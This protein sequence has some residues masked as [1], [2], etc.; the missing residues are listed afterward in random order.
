MDATSTFPHIFQ[1]LQ[2]R[3]LKLQNRIAISGHHAGWWVDAGRP[4]EAFVDYIEERAKGGVGLFV[5][6][7]TSPKPG[8]GWLESL[9]E[10]IIPRYRACVEAGHRHGVPIFAQLAHP[11]YEPL[12]GPPLTQPIPSAAPIQPSRKMGPRFTPSVADLKD[13]VLSFGEAACRAVAGGVDGIEIHSHEW[14]LFSQMINPIWNE[15]TDEYGGCLEN[16]MRLMLETF[17]EIRRRIGDDITMGVRLKADDMEQRGDTPTDYVE[18]LHRL[19][20]TGMIDYVNFTGGDARFHHGPSPRPEGEW[21][22]LVHHLKK[23]TNLKIMHAGRVTTAEMAEEA[24]RD[25]VADVICMTKSHI[26]DGRFMQKVR[27]GRMEDIRYCT[28]CL[29]SCHGKMELM[30]CVYNPVTSRE[31]DWAELK[32]AA[33][34]RKVVIIGA[35]PAGMEAALIAAQRG[36]QVTVLEKESRVGGQIWVGAASPMRKTWSRIA[37]F[38][39]R[40]AHKGMF[41][42]R[43]GCEATAE[44]VASLNPEVVILAAGSTPRRLQVEADRKAHTVHEVLRGELDDSR[45]VV[46]VD[47]EGFYR[48]WV[49]ADYLSSRDIQ[50]EFVTPFLT[51]GPQMEHWTLDEVLRGLQKRGVR[52]YPG[53]DLADWNER[54][55]LRDVQLGTETTLEGVDG[56]VGAIGSI[57]TDRLAHPLR[58]GP[59]E[60]HIIGD[61]N[62]PQTVEAATFQGGR[63]GRLL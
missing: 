47:R 34:R 54:A 1:P 42:V 41:E 13:L 43:L 61:A 62:F 35:G 28:R 12:P 18:V 44:R 39:E 50:V 29:Q 57:A 25:G 3:N 8:S 22:P 20:A 37:E 4:S 38:Y 30:T 63:I 26:A 36:H 53:H 58:A 11:G 17:Q 21:L 10:Q 5:I 27:E 46:I 24:L 31:R 33:Q 32:P 40:Q 48:P 6:G 60:L 2:L 52:F 15:R 14:F 56:I 51:V 7:C 59:W 9:D 16:R 55:V 19:E 23:Q 45:H 49:V